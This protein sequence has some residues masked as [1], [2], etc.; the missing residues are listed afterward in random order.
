MKTQTVRAQRLQRVLYF[1]CELEDWREETSP[2]WE[3]RHGEG[4]RES[5]LRS[6]ERSLLFSTN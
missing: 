4:S 5:R 2:I 3:G 6:D 1:V